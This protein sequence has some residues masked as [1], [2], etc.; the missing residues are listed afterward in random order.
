MGLEAPSI[1]LNGRGNATRYNNNIETNLPV[2]NPFTLNFE[3]KKVGQRAKR[4]LLRLIN[5]SFETTFV[6]SIDN[7]L[8]QIVGADFVPIHPYQNTS[9]LIGIGQRYNVI[10]TADP[11]ANDGKQIPPSGNYWIRTWRAD[12]FLFPGGSPGYEKSGILTYTGS[13]ALPTTSN[14]SDIALACSDETYSSLVPVVPWTVGEPANDP[15]GEVGENFTV[16][17]KPGQDTIFPLAKFS[18]GGDDFNPLRI[19]YGDPTFLNLNYTGKWDPLWVVFPENY[20]STDWV[21]LFLSA[22]TFCGGLVPTPVCHAAKIVQLTRRI[23]GV[24]GLE[25]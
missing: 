21:S 13:P 11:Q 1:L 24:H 6:F 17:F 25:G 20:T 22:V 3:P 5:T 8:L 2:P 12:C 7:H 16:Q 10:V 15:S 19:D 14:W 18:M 23:L 9:V 4:Y